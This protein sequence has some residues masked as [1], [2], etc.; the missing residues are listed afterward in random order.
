MNKQN[1]FAVLDRIH[2]Q[3]MDEHITEP[4]EVIDMLYDEFEA[5]IELEI[6]AETWG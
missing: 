3:I 4:S 6:D 2:A 1:I 5:E